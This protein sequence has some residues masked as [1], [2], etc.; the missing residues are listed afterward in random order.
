[1]DARPK[2]YIP[3]AS[4]RVDHVRER[5]RER[6]LER[7]RIQGN[8]REISHKPERWEQGTQS[9]LETRSAYRGFS[10]VSHARGPEVGNEG[11]EL[12]ECDDADGY[13]GVVVAKHS[14]Y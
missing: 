2:G 8:R 5:G 4:T 6:I 10:R 13:G 1:M 9:G 12:H 11:K 14:A 3:G 7:D